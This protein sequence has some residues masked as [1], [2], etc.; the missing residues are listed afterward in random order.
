MTM[1]I[2]FVHRTAQD[3]L[4]GTTEGSQLLAHDK[5]ALEERLHSHLRTALAIAQLWDD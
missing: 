3:Y 4:T 1:H 2:K 5:S